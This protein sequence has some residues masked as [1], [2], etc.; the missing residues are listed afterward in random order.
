MLVFFDDILIYNSSWSEH[1]RHVHLVLTAL[2]VHKLFIKRSK[3]A[4]GTRSVAYLGHVISE[5]GVTMDQHKVQA[6]VDW[7]VPHTVRVVRVF[8]GLTGYYQCFIQDYGSIAELLTRLLRKE[9]FKWTTEAECVFCALHLALTCA[10]VLLLS[11]FNR[12]FIVAPSFTKALDRWLSSA[13]RS[14]HATP[15]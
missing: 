9:G 11:A 6:V 15:S 13:A 12:A 5:K 8:L 4:F 7:P 14:C 3:C 10:P 1:L 2:Q